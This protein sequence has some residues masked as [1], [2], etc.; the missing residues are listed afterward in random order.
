MLPLQNRADFPRPHSLPFVEWGTELGNAQMSTGKMILCSDS[1]PGLWQSYSNVYVGIFG[2]GGAAH[3]YFGQIICVEIAWRSG[4]LSPENAGWF[5]V[6]LSFAVLPIGLSR[7][8]A[9]E[10]YCFV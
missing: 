2:L 9:L 8:A 6:L 1:V 4:S 10:L 3:W 5:G 7:T